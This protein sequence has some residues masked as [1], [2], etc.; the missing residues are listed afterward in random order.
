MKARRMKVN[1]V[2]LV[3]SHLQSYP[4]PLQINS[5]WILGFLL[6]ITLNPWRCIGEKVR[7]KPINV[8]AK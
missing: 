4:C 6:G 2:L 1:F 3:K 5:F 8:D 7:R